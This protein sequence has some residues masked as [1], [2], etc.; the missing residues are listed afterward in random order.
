MPLSSHVSLLR[1]P[2]HVD[3]KA[4]RHRGPLPGARVLPWE[5]L[6]TIN[7]CE[8][9]PCRYSRLPPFPGLLKTWTPKMGVI[10][11]LYLVAGLLPR[12]PSWAMNSC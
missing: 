9:T 4:G 12:E 11:D 6:R 7:T 1:P 8:K 3:S 2:E 10:G 5:V